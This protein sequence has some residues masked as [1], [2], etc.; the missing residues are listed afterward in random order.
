MVGLAEVFY[1]VVPSASPRLRFFLGAAPLSLLSVIRRESWIG[2][3]EGGCVAPNRSQFCLAVQ[4]SQPQ[5]R[6]L[7]R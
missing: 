4:L 7:E 2:Y 1:V 3:H 5:Q 6:N